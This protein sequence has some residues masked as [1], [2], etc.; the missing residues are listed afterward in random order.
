MPR[1]QLPTLFAAS[2]CMAAPMMGHADTSAESFSLSTDGQAI[3]SSN[4]MNAKGAFAGMEY[5]VI[6]GYAVADAD[7][8]LGKVD[9]RGALIERVNRG[10][11]Q[12]SLFDRWTNGVIPYQF[13]PHITETERAMANQAIDHWNEQTSVTFV[14]MND[15]NRYDFE[16]YLTFESSYGCASYVGMRGGEQSLWISEG[17]DV[18]NVIH[19]LGHVVGLFHEHTRSDRDNHIA[20]DWNNIAPG[21]EFNFDVLNA[22]T[23]LLGDYDYASIMHYG[24]DSFSANG[25]KTIQSLTG[26]PIG[27]RIALSDKDIESVNRLYETDLAVTLYSSAQVNEGQI[28]TDV[29][30]TNQGAMGSHGLE[31]LID[32]GANAQWISVS[33]DSGWQCASADSKVLCSRESLTAGE[34]SSFTLLAAAN[35]ANE[36]MTV[37]KLI[38]KTRDIDY[39]NNAFNDRLDASESLFSANT[40]TNAQQHLPEA[41]AIVALADPIEPVLAA[42]SGDEP[43]LNEPVTAS[44]GSVSPLSALGLLLSF[45]L[46]QLRTRQ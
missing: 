31:L 8:V 22:G 13:G 26:E 20:I 24:E 3:H 16:N 9:A 25:G 38:A 46:I 19:E 12:S 23:E 36:D 45:G 21:K 17:C 15:Q 43:N 11:G 30:I 18:G 29:Q 32:A 28:T 2:M 14:A 35:N 7:M 27:Q 4:R 42:A 37:A 33:S 39:S 34:T 40:L 1:T 10:L 41:H 6:N 5:E 44:M